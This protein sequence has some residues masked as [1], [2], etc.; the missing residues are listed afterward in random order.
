MLPIFEKEVK[1]LLDEK[2]I[3]PLRYSEWI[4]NLVPVRKKIGETR[5]CVEFININKLALKDNYPLL[6]MDQLLEKV[7]GSNRISM[8]DGFFRYNQILVSPKDS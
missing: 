8:L 3:V 1:K 6:K 7:S 5:L 2:I 4:D